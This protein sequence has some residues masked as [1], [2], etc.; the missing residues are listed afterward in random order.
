MAFE[1]SEQYLQ[2][3]K[4]FAETH[5]LENRRRKDFMIDMPP[6]IFSKHMDMA[7]SRIVTYSSSK[8]EAYIKGELT[9]IFLN[10]ENIF[11]TIVIGKL[12]RGETHFTPLGTVDVFRQLKKKCSDVIHQ[13]IIKL[14]EEKI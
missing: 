1:I 5:L 13:K 8:E 2:H 10:R 6:A 7:S 3:E 9:T 4:F 14:I 12:K 11:R